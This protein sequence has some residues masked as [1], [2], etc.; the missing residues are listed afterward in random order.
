MRIVLI[1][2]GLSR[3]LRPILDSDLDVVGIVESM[4]RNYHVKND[5]NLVVKS[6]TYLYRK[7]KG[8]T[9]SLKLECENS[10]VKYNYICKGRDAEVTNWVEK[11][12]PDLIVIY[13]MSQLI[14]KELIDIPV[15]GVINMHPSSLPDYRGANP[16]F[17][18]YYNMEM[19]PG[20]T[21]HYV[22]EGEDTGDIIYQERVHVSLGTK[23]PERLDKLISETG[24]PLMFQ[25]IQAIKD[26]RAPRIPQPLESPNERA[27][28]LKDGEHGTII[29]WNTWPIERV[30]HVLRGT[31]LWLNAIAQPAGLFKGQRW[32]IGD[33]LKQ[34]N[35]H[36][37]G[38]VVKLKGKR[39]V[40][41]PE[42]YIFLSVNFNFKRAVL[43]F[44]KV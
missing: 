29:D 39:V 1:T 43:N 16:D 40:A 37:P 5:Q 41:V 9:A 44:L 25:A 6:I 34:S 23:S 14:K 20:V 30:W 22:N 19:N 31:E 42:G 2:Q 33:Y 10:G 17:W 12:K 4:P 26:G 36:K 18:Q 21:V 8:K 3:L 13:S 28:N 35:Q 27:R 7:I 24:V 38:S 32:E 15:L 11:L